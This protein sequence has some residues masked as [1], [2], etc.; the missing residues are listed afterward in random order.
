MRRVLG[1]YAH[2]GL[3]WKLDI[4]LEPPR[5]AG[6]LALSPVQLKSNT[7]LVSSVER[8]AWRE[9]IQLKQNE[10]GCVCVWG[11]IGTRI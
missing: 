2:H 6:A 9:N 3:I 4:Q 7:A 1:S 8:R 10:K 5:V 11:S